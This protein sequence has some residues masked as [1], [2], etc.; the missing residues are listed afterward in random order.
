MQ[1]TETYQLNLIESSDPFSH[2]PLNDN[3]VKLEAAL[4]AQKTQSDADLTDFKQRSAQTLSDLRT[5]MLQAV[6]A[7]RTQVDHAL[8]NQ[9]TQASQALSDLRTEM[10]QSLAAQPKVGFVPFTGTGEGNVVLTFPFT[11]RMVLLTAAK[12]ES[13][14][15]FMAVYGQTSGYRTGDFLGTPSFNMVWSGTTLTLKSDGRTSNPI[16]YFN[17]KDSNYMAVAFA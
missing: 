15:C 8:A 5:E 14:S 1:Q 6:E 17:E 3:A 9:Q 16:F 2:Q 7:H 13:I 12:A 4:T 10:S 11:P